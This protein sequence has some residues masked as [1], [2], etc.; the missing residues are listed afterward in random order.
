MTLRGQGHLYRRGQVWWLGYYHRGRYIRESLKTTDAKKA[1]RLRQ[2]KLKLVNTPHFVTPEQEKLTFDDLAELLR[3]DYRLNGRRSLG[4]VERHIR[5]L[6][7]AFA[8]DR[9]L[10]ITPDRIAAY[11]AAR[12]GRGVAPATVNRELAAL[13]RM[14]SLA[15]KTGQILARPPITLLTEDNAREGFAEPAEFE[16]VAAHLPP[17]YADAARFAYLTGWR[18]TEVRTLEWRDITLD[19][20]G[21]TVVGGVIRLRRSHSKTKQGRTLVLRGALLDLART[22]VAL[23]RLDCP[24]VFHTDGRR[25][26]DLQ[27]AWRRAAARAGIA[28]RFIHDLRRSAVR[29]M[30]RAGVPERVAMAISGHK[31]R[32]VFDRYNIVSEA[33]LAEAAERVTTYVTT[34]PRSAPVA[35]LHREHAQFAHTQAP[36]A[37][38]TRS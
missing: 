27:R 30:V 36:K 38:T 4:H 26:G 20:Q 32:S 16:A 28:G 37:T 17:A 25:L 2:R 1:E 14:F 18:K 22:R 15:V 5:R 6:G 10:S 9:A 12:L 13:R 35:P 31:T 24:Y 7:E 23:R 34:A 8:C 11:T 19:R 3:T 29:N 33:D 21:G